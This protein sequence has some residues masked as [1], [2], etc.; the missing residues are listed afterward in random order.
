MMKKYFAF[1]MAFL[2][3]IYITGCVASGTV[4]IVFDIDEFVSS[5]TGMEVVEV[6]LT[7]NSDYNDNKDKIK[8]IDQVTVAG[9][10]T[11]LESVDNQ[12]E[13]WLAYTGEYDTPA[14]VRDNATRIFVSPVIPGD[15]DLLINW[16]DGLSHI[17]N[18]DALKDAAE[19]GHFWLYG[20]AADSP[21][22]VRFRITL[23]I[24]MTAGL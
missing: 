8:S 23:V 9:T 1:A 18:L 22:T 2:V 13:I 3:A 11:N 20:L 4:I 21:F 19:A 17:E 14:E 6:D 24:T 10:L 12:A 7:T 5:S 15:D 16:A